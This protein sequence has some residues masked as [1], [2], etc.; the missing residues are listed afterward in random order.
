MQHVKI[1]A[2]SYRVLILYFQV[3]SSIGFQFHF[4]FSW[5]KFS[6]RNRSLSS[7]IAFFQAEL[8]FSNKSTGFR[9]VNTEVIDFFPAG[10]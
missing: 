1:A 4:T 9:E 3:D 5:P 2:V 6:K 8:V 10:Y 7:E